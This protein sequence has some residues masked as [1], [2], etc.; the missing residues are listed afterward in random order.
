[1]IGK[2]RW[3]LK[4]GIIN[5]FVLFIFFRYAGC[6]DNSQKWAFIFA[7]SLQH[8]RNIQSKFNDFFPIK[9]LLFLLE[10]FFNFFFAFQLLNSVYLEMR[11]LNS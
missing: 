2:M 6:L 1:M 7:L 8:L 4:K 9:S 10:W 5:V 3:T 11:N